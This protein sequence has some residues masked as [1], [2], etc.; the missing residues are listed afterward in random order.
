MNYIPRFI[1]EVIIYYKS[2]FQYLI[3]SSFSFCL[4]IYIVFFKF[5]YYF[6]FEI[7]IFYLKIMIYNFITIYNFINLKFYT[8]DI[9]IIVFYLIDSK[10]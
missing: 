5:F 8:S 6:F 1:I 10:I 2:L 9:I 3:I 7:Y 4:I